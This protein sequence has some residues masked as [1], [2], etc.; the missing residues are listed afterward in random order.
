[1]I[2]KELLWFFGT[3]SLS[4]LFHL[5]LDGFD[6]FTA[7]STLDI[8][9]HD[10]YFVIS[11]IIFFTV[12]S[13][14]LFFFVY[15]LRMLCSNFKNLYANFVFIIACALIVLILTS[16]I[17]LIQ[18]MSNVFD[19]STLNVQTHSLRSTIGNALILINA[20][21]VLFASFVGFKTG[22]NYKQNKHSP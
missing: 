12:L 14:L 19:A 13:A 6:S 5:F 21:L 2:R 10:T 18:S 15:L 11:D 3:L 1:M 20:L 4:L 8:N 9:I 7:D 16:S 22:W 17:S